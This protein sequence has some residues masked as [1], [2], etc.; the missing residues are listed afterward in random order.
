[1]ITQSVSA[2][3]DVEYVACDL[4]GANDFADVIHARDSNWQ[5]HVESPNSSAPPD[6]RQ[7][8]I[9]S[10]NNCGLA[11]LNPRPTLAAIGSCY[12]P[13]YYA[14][15]PGS[16]VARPRGLQLAKRAM[17]RAVR[18]RKWPFSL[19]LGVGGKAVFGDPVTQL[20]GWVPV[21][22]ILE[23]GCGA[24]T[25]LDGFKE[26][27]WT[28]FGVDISAA[29]MEVARSKGHGA[30][31]GDFVDAPL[32]R[33]SFDVVWMSHVLE[34]TS[35][36]LHAL[37]KAHAVL[38]PGGIVVVFVP[39]FG[40]VWTAVFR[41]RNWSLDLPRHLYHFTRS[42]LEQVAI[43]AG[44]RVDRLC[45]KAT[46]K[47]FLCNIEKSLNENQF[48]QWV[49]HK[50]AMDAMRRCKGVDHLEKFRGWLE[51]LGQGNQLMLIGT[52]ER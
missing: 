29:A 8:R 37:R 4:C 31:A 1:M 20:L 30:W 46:Q 26:R 43:A 41:E 9:V 17:R 34:H 32:A 27:G 5:Y 50:S 42:S 14:Y 52:K 7:W 2:H 13:S 25:C 40:S 11:Y 22:S 3:L 28:T 10:C 6:D 51:S 48:E 24:G 38:S 19:A 49:D 36:P 44:F 23:V 47:F 45:T 18:R 39:N 12:P 15:A 33:G 21:G 16:K 35:S